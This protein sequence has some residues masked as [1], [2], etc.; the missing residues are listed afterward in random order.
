MTLDIWR[1]E[2]SADQTSVADE[3]EMAVLPDGR[4]VMIWSEAV[5]GEGN[6]IVARV[7]DQ[8]GEP[9]GET[10]IVDEQGEMSLGN[11]DVATDGNGG[12]RAVYVADSGIQQQVR[13]ID[14]SFGDGNA[15]T[16]GPAFVV[17]TEVPS[18]LP[19]DPSIT[20]LGDDEYRIAYQAETSLGFSTV[21]GSYGPEGPTSARYQTNITNNTTADE[22]DLKSAIAVLEDGKSVVIH[23]Q[24]A[25]P[26]VYGEGLGYTLTNESGATIKA[27]QPIVGAVGNDSPDY[28]M[29]VAAIK[30]GF[31][32]AWRVQNGADTD[33]VYAR[34]DLDGN[35]QGGNV[36]LVSDDDADDNV[37][38]LSAQ[39][40]PDGG[41]ALIWVERIVQNQDVLMVQTFDERGDPTS[42]ATLA[43]W[44]SEDELFSD[45]QIDVLPDGRL[46]LAYS[47]ETTDGHKHPTYAILDGREGV[48]A[49]EEDVDD[50]LMA[51]YLE[52]TVE[53]KSGDDALYAQGRGD[54]LYGGAGDD[55]LYAHLGADHLYGGSGKDTASF[56]RLNAGIDA[57]L[58][59]KVATIQGSFF[60]TATLNSIENL[61]G[62]V[63]ADI[64][65]GDDG[66][67]LIR[68]LG[69]NDNLYGGGGKDTLVGGDGDD[70]LYHS[71]GNDL[72]KGGKGTDVFDVSGRG[73]VDI[74]GGSGS[75]VVNFAKVS[76]GGV[77]LDLKAG[78]FANGSALK[79]TINGIERATGTEQ[80]DMLF[81]TAEDDWLV[82]G[83]GSDK[84]VGRGGSDTL[85]GG[86]GRDTLL[87]GGG[88]D[89]LSGSYGR[90]T[91]KGGA[92]DDV[93]EGGKGD[94]ALYGGDG[95]DI[96]VAGL[97]KDA[98]YGG[99][100][101]DTF[102]AGYGDGEMAGGQ[103]SD[104][105]NYVYFQEGVTVDLNKSKQNL[106]ED[107]GTHTYSG[108]ENVTGTRFDDELSGNDKDNRIK[109]DVGDDV[110]R[111]RQGNDS[112]NGDD[113]DD[114]LLGGH[115]RDNLFGGDGD[116][117]LI[118]GQGKD[119]FNGGEGNDLLDGGKNDGVLDTFVFIKGS[120][121]DTV[122][123]F[124][125]GTDIIQLVNTSFDSFADLNGRITEVDGDVLIDLGNGDKLTI[126]D[127]SLTD[128]GADDLTF[129]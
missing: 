106:G 124:E 83:G 12:I 5:P 62:S 98:M 128:F 47:M 99:K 111:G 18:L 51:H 102:L 24:P 78:T 60:E 6:R 31:V 42:E 96:L 121:H 38:S 109:G 15:P 41:F 52:S 49:G 4:F 1:S 2:T 39:S 114:R 27:A 107:I 50:L 80:S 117:S 54:D 74:Y 116:D 105:V 14:I 29:D 92:G 10:F 69:G 19:R 20:Y 61:E 8:L 40:L 43:D 73:K 122:R 86:D 7:F 48:V 123:N 9:A 28:Q 126:E 97:G 65:H 90:D 16:I 103:G 34:Y 119:Y 13:A 81:G 79:G 59:K 87:G 23:Y 70:Y 108:I 85:N 84:L 45:P 129:S 89:Y 93:L 71:R 113:G 115:G 68:G 3:V 125:D 94:D 30:G 36:N 66:S 64:L 11:I 22:S 21:V 17:A 37:Q 35:P 104:A 58:K 25:L 91:I 112:L 67:N 46:V 95:R 82:G 44:A 101:D 120:D 75:D 32:V 53:G 110:L 100:D 55:K 56:E 63:F 127:L 76:S 33:V 118:G 88:D 77:I 57:S 72:M 26:G